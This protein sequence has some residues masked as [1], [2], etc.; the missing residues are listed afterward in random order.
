MAKRKVAR[1][2]LKGYNYQNYIFTLF[3]AKMDTERQII[4]IE[5]ESLNTK[6]FD[7]LY[8]GMEDGTS[9]HIQAKN[10]AGTQIEDII[11]TDHIVK[12]KTN[13]NQYENTDNNVLIVNTDRIATDTEFIGLPAVNKDGIIIIP[14]TEEQVTEYLDEFYQTEERELQ[15]IQKAIEFTCAERFIVGI[16]DLP[17]LITLSTDLQQQTVI[18]RKVPKCIKQGI[19]FYVG[20]PGVGKSHFVD[21]LKNTFQDSIIYRFWIGSQDE[22]LRRRL[23]FDKFLTELGLLIYK[24]PR[25]FTVD[26][27]IEEIVRSNQIIIIDGLDHVENYNPLEVEKYIE[28]ID[29]LE[30]A[31]VRVVVL[32]RPLQIKVKWERTELLN[33]NVDEVRLYLAMSHDI[34]DYK[35]QKQILEIAD[36]YPIITYFLAEHYKKN[37]KINLDQPVDSLNQYYDNLLKDV[38]TKSL[39]C[40]FATNNSFFTWNE[41]LAFLD[42]S[43]FYDVLKE[44]IISYQYLFEIVEN[45][46]SLIHDSLNTYLRDLLPSFKTHQSAVL[47]FVKSSLTDVNSEYMARLAS[48]D[49]DDEFLNS[50]LVKYSNFEIFKQLLGSTLDYNSVT[51][52]YKQLQRILETRENCLDIYQY[53]SFCLIYQAATRNDLVGCDGLIYQILH[54]LHEHDSIENQIFSSGIMWNLYLACKQKEDMTKRYIESKN[55]S[56]G[57]FYELI[58]SVNDE[59]TFYNRLEKKIS[60]EEIEGTLQNAQIDTQ[61][62]ADVLEEYLI[63]TWIHGDSKEVFHDLFL[64]YLKTEEKALFRVDL[65][66]YGLDDFWAEFIPHRARIKLHELGFFG[67]NNLY[68][69]MTLMEKIKECAPE[70]SFTVLPVV[71]SVVRL[72]NYENR[73]IDIYSVNYAWTMYGQRKDYSVYTIEDALIIFEEKGLIGEKESVELICKLMSQSEKGIRHLISS[74]INKK[75]SECT[76]RLIRTGY[77]KNNSFKADIFDLLP[78]NINCFSKQQLKSRIDD[79]LYYSRYLKTVEGRDICYVL[80]SNYCD[81]VL[82]ALEYYEYSVFG[83]IEDTIA[84]KLMNRGIK[85]LGENTKEEKEYIPFD[86]G[87]IREEDIEYIKENSIAAFEI[88]R[89]ADGWYSCLPFPEIYQLYEQNEMKENFLLVLH[90]SMFARVIDKEYIGN[91]SML[92]GNIPRFLMACGIAVNWNKLFEIFN[93][94]MNVSLIYLPYQRCELAS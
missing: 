29:K 66:K 42:E 53:Y 12:I 92:L 63:S 2:S 11:I 54:Y 45:R 32:S 40:I 48:F 6:Q 4:K 28:F 9:Y 72:A 21:E 81:M 39:L 36:G 90:K 16:S 49:L 57:Q 41:L 74:Y 33:W 8:I 86:G 7:D 89:Y 70:G 62:K 55:Y 64:E 38:K 93:Q 44:F 5:S 25:S 84:Q 52:F 30:N 91:W 68:R 79:M 69:G 87:Y 27:L 61:K 43:G 23:Q 60:F 80:E 83:N 17:E 75:G 94:F 50:L 24:T 14:L 47:N 19:T 37:G 1:N 71:L 35:V 59:I 3:L 85:Y 15:I 56:E 26:E 82:D 78:E 18:L 77:F 22:Q 34:T 10:Y 88:A 13:E 65:K 76:K 31:Q 46:I 51:S 67:E 58:R 73:E 20:K